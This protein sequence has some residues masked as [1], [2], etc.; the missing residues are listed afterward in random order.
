MLPPSEDEKETPSEEKA[1]TPV[2]K[3]VP[4]I[5]HHRFLFHLDP[6]NIHLQK[7]LTD[8]PTS[9]DLEDTIATVLSSST[10]PTTKSD[11]PLS[12]SLA[13]MPLV[14]NPECLAKLQII[15]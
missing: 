1:T 7:V 9:P 11:T 10:T 12:G 4:A 3:E 13:L 15:P 2:F 6:L 14:F 5:H 8:F